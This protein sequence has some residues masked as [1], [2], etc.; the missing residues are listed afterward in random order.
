MLVATEITKRLLIWGVLAVS[1]V[2]RQHIDRYR[3]SIGG[4]LSLSF[5]KLLLSICGVNLVRFVLKDS[6]I[7][8]HFRV[9][10]DVLGIIQQFGNSFLCFLTPYILQTW[11][12]PLIN[13][14]GRPGASLMSP[15]YLSTV[16]SASSVLL[17]RLYHPNFWSLRK[18][19][20]AVSSPPVLTTLRMFNTVS[21]QGGHHDGRGNIMSQTLMVIEYWFIATQIACAIGFALDRRNDKTEY[22]Q[23]DE[24]LAGFREIAFV[25]DWLRVCGHAM[26]VNQLDELYLA[27]SSGPSSGRTE[28]GASGDDVETDHGAEFTSLVRR[29]TVGSA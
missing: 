23:L 15:L 25:S 26:F 24:L 7:R 17:A 21:T 27:S 11:L 6:H 20:N 8:L 10:T 5:R 29:P 19:G 12:A 1:V 28:R 13:I 4:S 9:L 2:P 22:N 16:L 18:I 3:W 14:G